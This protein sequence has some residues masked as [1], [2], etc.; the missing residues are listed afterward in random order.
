[1][2]CNEYFICVCPRQFGTLCIF[3]CLGNCHIPYHLITLHSRCREVYILRVL[4]PVPLDRYRRILIVLFSD[5]YISLFIDTPFISLIHTLYISSIKIR[6]FELCNFTTIL[7][8]FVEYRIVIPTK[9][10]IN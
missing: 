9:R 8:E 7:M 2:R 3:Y 6:L 5:A 1:M 10:L 4:D